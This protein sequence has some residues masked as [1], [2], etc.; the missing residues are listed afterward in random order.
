[1]S[2]PLSGKRV[3]GQNGWWARQS[4]AV[5]LFVVTSIT[6]IAVMGIIVVIAAWQSRV[7]AVN[8]TQRELSTSLRSMDETLQMVFR[9]ASERGDAIIPVVE[10]EFGGIPTLD[11]RTLRMP[12]NESVP[13]LVVGD[14]IVNGDSALLE[15]INLNTG[16]DPAVLV[17]SGGNW[18]R[19]ATLLK[20]KEGGFRNGSQLAPDDVLARA[21]DA[22]KPYGGLIQRNN[23]WYAIS[24][25]PLK[26]ENGHVYAGISARVDV[27]DEIEGLLQLIEETTVAEH[28]T[29]GVLRRSD[30]GSN[31]VQVAGSRD[32]SLMN[33]I[34]SVSH[35]FSQE[36]GFADVMLGSPSSSTFL[37]WEFVP[38]WNWNLY[39]IGNQSD[40]LAQSK[41]QILLQSVLLLIGTLIIS[42]MVGWLAAVTLRPVRQVIEG[43]TRLGEGDLTIEVEAVPANSRSE[44]HSLLSNLRLTRENLE[45]TI[46]AV[47]SSVNE[48]NMGAAEIATGNTDLSSRTEQQAAALQE[49]A[50]SMEELAVTVK[51]N[52]EHARHANAL[53]VN[54]H[55]AAGRGEAVVSKVVESMQQISSSSGQIGAIVNVIEAIAFQ[56]NILALNAAVEAARA[57]EQG[58]GFAVVASEVRSLAQRSD[59]SAK[60]IKDLIE[61]SLAQIK[62]GSQE[63]ADAGT[64]MSDLLVSVQHV[65]S[66]MKEIAAASE[67]Q[68][69]GIEQVNLAVGQMDMVTQQNSA[70]VEQ[71][72]AAASSLQEQA[73]HL[74]DAIAVFRV[75]HNPSGFDSQRQHLPTSHRGSLTYERS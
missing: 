45:R 59:D 68:S 28:G 37:A 11:G 65:T 10:R 4:L 64:A 14:Y 8:S 17:R 54:A 58:R 16:A 21:L 5:R 30:D 25:K 29:L 72:A 52:T 44:V 15:R 47:R 39:A 34:N 22:G 26:D 61:A 71:A 49:T 38:N 33:G 2:I 46:A 13:L 31:W 57:G 40:F 69:V 55:E 66:L 62:T 67:E 48:I 42:L 12:E 63:V 51:Q 18:L 43:M 19:A 24:V 6:T 74:A 20:N 60:E 27:N 53:A 1:M 56:T 73:Q 23:R 3:A 7:D 70:L 9:G 32:A 50:A 36:S 75:D 41:R 35:L